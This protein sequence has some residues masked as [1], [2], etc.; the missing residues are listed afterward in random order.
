M[1]MA[2]ERLL[3]AANRDANGLS[4]C[5][6][7][8]LGVFKERA[9]TSAEIYGAF[10][11]SILLRLSFRAEGRPNRRSVLP[12]LVIASRFIPVCHASLCAQNLRR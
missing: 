10:C 5:R 4:D 2:F 6:R 3:V 8:L 7:K 11:S 1:M 9:H 12:D